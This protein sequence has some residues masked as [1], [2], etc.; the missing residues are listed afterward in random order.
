MRILLIAFYFP[1]YN[2]IGS[3]RTGKLAKYLYSHG[4]DIRVLTARSLPLPDDLTLEVPADLVLPSS[5]VN[6]NYLPELAAGGRK[7]VSVKGYASE[8]SLAKRL[9]TLYKEIFNFPDE[10]VGW[11]LYGYCKAKQVVSRWKPDLIYASATP[12]SSLII[13]ALLSKFFRIPW[14]AELR[15]LW[16]GNQTHH[17]TAI[18]NLFEKKLE[19]AVLKTASA[20]VTVSQPL[21]DTLKAKYPQP[22]HVI[23]NG[24][25]PDDYPA[26]NQELPE[27]NSTLMISYTGLMVKD[28]RDP[29]PLF[30][31]AAELAED[32]KGIHINFYGRYSELVLAL[33]EKYHLSD[34]VRAYPS[35][36][37]K[38]SL[39]IQ[40]ESD[41]L[42]HL[43]WNDIDQPGILT[44][45]LYE[46]LGARRPILAVGKY[47]YQDEAA[48]LIVSRGAGLATNDPNVIKQQLIDWINVKQQKGFISDLPA[49]VHQGLTR[50]D[51][52]KLLE[53]ILLDLVAEQKHG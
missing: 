31:A 44:G 27:Q 12:Y 4:H 19:K 2:T 26:D 14:V 25:D 28:Y 32:G 18:R 53:Q 30:Q 43:L 15:D 11:I 16:I 40:K 17:H 29:S 6:V 1:P 21:A 23:Q 20:I 38:D 24:F 46:Y 48:Q 8:S 37:Y 36:S 3:M 13:A 5:W 22:V 45:K 9:G 33:A 47:H 42:L 10:A 39:Q 51:Q 52:F 41:V 35:V 34:Q 49:S 7:N 50:A